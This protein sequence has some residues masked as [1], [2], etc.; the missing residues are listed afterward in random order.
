MK[1][2]ITEKTI[3]DFAKCGA[4]TYLIDDNTLITPSAKDLARSE[5]IQFISSAELEKNSY[6]SKKSNTKGS[7]VNNSTCIMEVN[8]K[9]NKIENLKKEEIVKLIIQT[10]DERGI[11]E[12]ILDK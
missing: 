2:L 5:G 10:L 1:N 12:K 6:A 8:P 9:K 4:K 7:E 11:L 3:A